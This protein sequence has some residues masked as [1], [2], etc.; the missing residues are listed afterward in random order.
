MD[1]IDGLRED[2]GTGDVG[3]A[4]NKDKDAEVQEVEVRYDLR[5]REFGHVSTELAAVGQAPDQADHSQGKP[6]Q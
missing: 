5:C 1:F 3:G 6:Q 2:A 4:E